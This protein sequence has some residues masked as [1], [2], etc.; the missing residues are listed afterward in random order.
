[1]LTH[2][3]LSHMQGSPVGG[4]GDSQKPLVSPWLDFGTVS[5]PDS[6]E[7][8]LWWAQYLWNSDGNYR[9]A[10]ERVAA[11]FMTEVELPD[12]ET[13]EESAWRALFRKQLNYRADL[14]RAGHDY[15]A[16]G[17]VFVGLY[18]PFRR[19]MICQGCGMEQPIERVE[20]DLRMSRSEPYLTWARKHKCQNCGNHDPYR[21]V[22]RR[23]PDLGRLKINLYSPMQMQMAQN[24]HSLRKEIRWK[25]DD[26]TRRDIEGRARIHIDD[27]PTEVLE[28]VAAGG[29]LKFE[30]GMLL[31]CAEPTL[32]GMNAKGWGIPRTISNFRTAWLQQLV[33]KADQAVAI[34][35]T[36]GIRLISPAPSP[37]GVDPMQNQ[38]MDNFVERMQAII[39]KHRNNPVSYHTSP[40]PMNYQFMGGE[41]GQLIPPDKLKFRH[42]EFLNQLG[43]PLEY[44]Q[45]SLSVQAAPMALRLFENFW[46]GI[47]ALYNQILEWLVDVIVRVYSLKP[48]AVRMQKSTF[49]DDMER[50]HA[51]VQLMSGNQISPQTALQPFG[52]DAHDEV[53]KVFRHQDYISRVQQ[54]FDDKEMKRQEMG[55]LKGMVQNETPAQMMERQMMEQGQGA[56]GAPPP[57]GMPMGG[58]PMGGL[59]AGGGQ[60]PQTL[61][62]MSEQAEMMAQQLAVMPE[63]DRKVQL[64]GLRESNKALHALVM[65]ALDDVRGQARSQGQQMLLAPPPGGA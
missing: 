5:L 41:G 34:D 48:T 63:Y 27:T 23:D 47:P 57:P 21:V 12:L 43:V 22:D 58:M 10:M 11:H 7:L 31:H 52:V 55:A 25:I 9:T 26:E 37:A 54:E 17:N 35:Y 33:N 59:P 44:H 13:D 50:K 14:L 15:L 16:Y 56:G 42:Q 29:H 65:Q 40:Y 51:L 3:M 2:P 1:M 36:L 64:K 45:M 46:Q 6:H 8:V 49:A 18:M 28:A 62:G 38:G 61:Q 30:E 32:S 19:M 39:S 4:Q 24:R 53:K 60:N 20:Y